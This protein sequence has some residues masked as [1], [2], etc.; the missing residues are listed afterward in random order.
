MRTVYIDVFLF[1]NMFENYLLLLCT[2]YILKLRC[3]AYRPVLGCLAAAILSMIVLLPVESFILNISATL[4]TCSIAVIISFG[5]HGKKLFFKSLLTLTAL[6]FLYSGAMIFLY[7]AIKPRGMVIINNRP[8]FDISPLL[9]IILTAAIYSLLFIYRKLFANHSRAN[10]LHS[11]KLKYKESICE[12]KAKED[13]ACNIKE[14][15]SGS[16]VIIVEKSELTF[17][18]EESKRR[19]IPFESLG[20]SGIIYAFKPD[21]VYIDERKAEQEIYIGICNE[22]LKTEIKGLIPES[23]LKGQ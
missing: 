3:K 2:R 17:S 7:L 9:L 14:P 11:V 23:V 1:I 22:I 16:S 8:Y 15:F 12:F 21:E 4:I 20:G 19:I 13:T 18:P 5:F 10:L 6:T